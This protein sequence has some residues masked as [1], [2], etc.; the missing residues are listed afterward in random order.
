MLQSLKR[1][2]GIACF[3]QINIYTSKKWCQALSITQ[4]RAAVDDQFSINK[5][6]IAKHYF[7]LDYD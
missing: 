2:C 7:T 1:F 4:A 5:L 6:A 3:G